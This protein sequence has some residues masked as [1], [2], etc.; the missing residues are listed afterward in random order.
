VVSYLAKMKKSSVSII[1][2][3]TYEFLLLEESKCLRVCVSELSVEEA[4]SVK[5]LC[6]N[7]VMVEVRIHGAICD[8]LRCEMS[9]VHLR[10]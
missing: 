8:I 4:T 3:T 5:A 6:W 2:S 7:K 9:E 1:Y 10:E